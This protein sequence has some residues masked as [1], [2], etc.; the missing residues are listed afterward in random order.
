MNKGY[1]ILARKIADSEIF[2]K[3]AKWFKIFV[4]LVIKASHKDRGNLKRGQ[5]FMSYETICRQC[6]TSNSVVDHA[7]RWMKKTRMLATQ[8]ATGGMIVTV[9]NYHTYQE[10]TSYASDSKSETKAT[11]PPVCGETKAIQKRHHITNIKQCKNDNK[12]ERELSELLLKLILERKPD[13]R[14]PNL[15][16]W[17]SH[18]DKMIRLDKRSPDRIREIIQWC[19][20]DDFWQNNIL[21]TEK[22]RKQF[23]KL[24]LRAT[25]A[26]RV[27]KTKLFPIPGKT[28][29]KQGCPLP[30]V[31]KNTSGNYDSYACAGHMP[32]KVKEQYA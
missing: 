30:A 20:A 14:K 4:Y 13:F 26:T 6:R 8:K 19:Q 32:E 5:C 15:E 23:D 24:E 21:S 17:A 1:I 16:K 27:Q 18:I 28:C 2:D 10:P 22:L 29:S 7:I 9:V 11:D 3:P 31:Y 12:N 25:K